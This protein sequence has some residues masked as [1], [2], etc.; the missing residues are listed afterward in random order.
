MVGPQKIERFR[1][2]EREHGF[3]TSTQGF[4]RLQRKCAQKAKREI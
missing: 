4:P 1:V 3:Y 2:S